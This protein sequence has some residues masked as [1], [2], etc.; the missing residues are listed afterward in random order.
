MTHGQSGTSIVLFD[1]TQTGLISPVSATNLT[2][3]DKTFTTASVVVSHVIPTGT[4]NSNTLTE[5]EV[6]NGTY[7]YNR[8]VRASF[9][10]TSSI[11]STTLHSFEFVVVQ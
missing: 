2:L 10:K 7:S 9:D 1:K 4:G 3:S 5:F 11:E 8:S 6:N